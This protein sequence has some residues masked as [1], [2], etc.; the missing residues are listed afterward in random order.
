[1]FQNHKKIS[2]FLI[3]SAA[4]ILFSG[5][6]A[7]TTLPRNP[8]P[9][10]K[11]DR[12]KVVGMPG[13]R[14]WGGR[15]SPELQADIAQSIRQEPP[16]MFPLGAD[17]S[18]NYNGLALS[19]GG[20]NGAFGAG[21]LYGWANKGT[22]PI[23]KIVTGISTGALIAPFAFLGSEYDDQL[24]AAYTTIESKDVF[25]LRSVFKML[26]NESFT[27]TGPLAGIV[28]KFITD[29]LMRDVAGAHKSGRRLF[30]GTTDMDAQRLVIWNMGA[31]AVSGRSNALE[32]FR[33]VLLASAS[34]PAIFPPVYFEVEVDGQRFDEMHTDGGTITQVFFHYGILDLEAAVKEAGMRTPSLVRSKMFII[35]N[36]KLGPEPKQTRRRLKEI[37]GRAVDTMIKSAAVGDL[38]RI[39]AFLNKRGIGFHYVGIPEDFVLEGDEV[40]DPEV[41]R[42]LFDLGYKTAISGDFWQDK[43]PGF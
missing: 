32:L 40:F 9:I 30:I 43:P 26:G 17:G 15:G 23:F 1:M 21:I 33:K 3:L 27:E 10:T 20:A 42:A 19:G 38:Y 39:Y 34:I 14:A 11:M 28:K 7:C 41:M 24:K 2:S 31:I 8:V 22:R 5:L 37:A 6:T 25:R 36:G 16:G 29:E 35:R 18:I 13:V 4:I 12:A